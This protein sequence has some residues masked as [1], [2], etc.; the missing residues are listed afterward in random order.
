ME[1]EMNQPVVTRYMHGNNT[2]CI[3][4]LKTAHFWGLVWPFCD[5]RAKRGQVDL[6]E[7]RRGISTQWLAFVNSCP[8][9]LVS[10]FIIGLILRQVHPMLL[11]PD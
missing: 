6:R 5:W 9:N 2:P 11:L 10:Q 1:R 8:L 7:A 3:M 4:K